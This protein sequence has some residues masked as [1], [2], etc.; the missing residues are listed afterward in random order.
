MG[1]QDAIE[2]LAGLGLRNGDAFLVIHAG[3]LNG[4]MRSLKVLVI[5]MGVL[6]VLGVIALAI[7]VTHR[8]DHPR[9]AVP[10]TPLGPTTSTLALPAGGRVVGAE[11]SGDR[12]VVRVELAAGGEELVVVNLATGMPISTVM[13]RPQPASP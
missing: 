1:G 2:P 8:I 6:L 4:S 11:A 13:L 7:A 12:L 3:N 10:A 5:T 9:A